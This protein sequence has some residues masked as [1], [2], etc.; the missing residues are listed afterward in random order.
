MCTIPTTVRSTPTAIWAHSLRSVFSSPLNGQT[1]VSD[2]TTVFH[3]QTP[4]TK[5]WAEKTYPITTTYPY[6]WSNRFLPT[7]D[8]NSYANWKWAMKT[9][10]SI[11][12]CSNWV[13]KKNVTT[14]FYSVYQSQKDLQIARDEV[15][16]QCKNAEIISKKA[17]NGLIPCE[18]QYQTEVNLATIEV[19]LNNQCISLQDPKDRFKLLIGM[20]LKEDFVLLPNTSVSL[21]SCVSEEAVHHGLE[22]RMEIRQQEID[23]EKICST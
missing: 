11:L 14:T 12:P 15:E 3:S 10:N 5:P 6:G 4:L 23:V 18:E 21:V 13:S 22:Q 19:S 8:P 9:R 16:N 2:C 7:T 17:E 1:A 20:P